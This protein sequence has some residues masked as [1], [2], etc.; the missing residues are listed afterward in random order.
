MKKFFAFAL[1]ASMMTLAACSGNKSEGT[2]ADTSA[3]APDTTMAAD[4]T[5]A[6]DT[7][8]AADTTKK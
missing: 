4:T 8:M 1:V 6:P 7:T 2:S 5:M 3:V